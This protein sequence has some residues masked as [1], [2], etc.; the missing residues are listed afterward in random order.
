[1]AKYM[2]SASYTPEGL[3]GVMKTGGTARVDAVREAVEALELAAE[4]LDRFAYGIDACSATR[5]HHAL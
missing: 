1:M 5:L 4:R 2:I 3:Q